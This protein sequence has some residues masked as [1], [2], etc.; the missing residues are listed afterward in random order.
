MNKEEEIIKE[1]RLRN[2]RR[3][4]LSGS[5]LLYLIFAIFVSLSGKVELPIVVQVLL[6]LSI[7]IAVG[8]ILGMIS[9]KLSYDTSIRLIE[10]QSTLNE[11]KKE[12]KDLNDKNFRGTEKFSK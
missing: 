12:F 5:G 9:V 11:M 1:K 3:N 8:L 2:K 4:V 7:G 6:P 10:I